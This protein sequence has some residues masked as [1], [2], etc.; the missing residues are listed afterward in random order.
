MGQNENWD[1]G[2]WLTLTLFPLELPL[3]PEPVQLVTFGAVCLVKHMCE[4]T[5]VSLHFIQRDVKGKDWKLKKVQYS[6][7]G[8]S[9]K[10]EARVLLLIPPPHLLPLS[11]QNCSEPWHW[12]C[13]L[14][15]FQPAII[16]HIS[17]AQLR[18]VLLCDSCLVRQPSSPYSS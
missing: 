3:P 14:S 5:S 18:A 16:P 17:T 12:W 8:R 13:P 6:R 7:W 2:K 11:S 15:A 4:K 10:G 1:L 9:G